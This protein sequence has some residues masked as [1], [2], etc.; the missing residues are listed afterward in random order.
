V[1]LARTLRAV[2]LG[3]AFAAAATAALRASGGWQQQNLAF[4]LGVMS[5]RCVHLAALPGRYETEEY[6]VKEEEA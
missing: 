1:S 6:G 3:A 4:G 2:R 5:P